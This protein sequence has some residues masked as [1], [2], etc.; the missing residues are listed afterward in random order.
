MTSQTAIEPPPPPPPTAPPPPPPAA[1]PPKLREAYVADARIRVAGA[2][3]RISAFL[4]FAGFVG[5]I[6]TWG[7]QNSIFEMASTHTET[8][9]PGLGYIA[10]PLLI[11]LVLPIVRGRLRFAPRRLYR[12]R[13]VSAALLFVAGLVVLAVNLGQLDPG[14][15]TRPGT[16]IAASLLVI[17]LLAT[18]AMWP[19]GLDVIRVDKSGNVEGAPPPPAPPP[20]AQPL[21]PPPQ[22]APVAASAQPAVPQQGPHRKTPIAVRVFAGIV[23][24]LLLGVIVIGVVQEASNNGGQSSRDAGQKAVRAVNRL[25]NG[26]TNAFNRTDP[27]VSLTFACLSRASNIDPYGSRL[28]GCVP[29]AERTSAQLGR[30]AD[31]LAATYRKSPPYARR[32]YRRAYRAEQGVLTI[33][34]QFVDSMAQWARV[35]GA[36][37]SAGASEFAVMRAARARVIASDKT[38]DRAMSQA[39]RQWHRYAARRWDVQFR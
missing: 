22:A 13:V 7:K 27:A 15:Q 8:Y 18:V 29:I 2:L 23:G 32:I 16:Y 12:A 26:M 38:Y 1:P 39:R 4:L 14:Y 9:R 11:L 3:G 6:A 34:R 21:P 19:A 35:H 28:S 25:D 10:G 24:A 17:G 37:S 31:R 5:S 20:V 33:H 36:S 30:S